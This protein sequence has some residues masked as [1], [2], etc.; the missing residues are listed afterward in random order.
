MFTFAAK[1]RMLRLRQAA[2]LSVPAA[3]TLRAKLGPSWLFGAGGDEPRHVVAGS[4]GVSMLFNANTGRWFVRGGTQPGPTSARSTVAGYVVQ[5]DGDTASVAFKALTI[6]QI[7]DVANMLLYGLPQVLGIHLQ[8]PCFVEHVIGTSSGGEFGYEAR[9]LAIQAGLVSEV[10]QNARV[11]R[12][13]DNLALFTMPGRRRVQA[14]LVY[15]NRGARR[16]DA[17]H[18]RW[19]F[20]SESVLNLAK[21]LESLFPPDGDGKTRDASRRGLLGLGYSEQDIEE[22]FIP[23]LALRS[24]LDVAHVWLALLA[25]DQIEALTAYAENALNRFRD[26]LAKVV[27]LSIDGDERIP[28]YAPGAGD[29][30]ATAMIDVIASRMKARGFVALNDQAH[31]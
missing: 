7:I 1:P 29:S 26:L 24:E 3:V 11:C 22:W 30:K 14:A 8:F 25:P 19:E 18:T 13:L 27:Q 23:A 2:T 12:A 10:D 5:L 9:A 28:E 20:M 15:F 31:H 6:D 21:V 4:I 16:L 17:G